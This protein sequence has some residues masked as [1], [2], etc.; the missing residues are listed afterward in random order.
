MMNRTGFTQTYTAAVRHL[1][2]SPAWITILG[3]AVLILFGTV[4]LILPL[5]TNGTPLAAVDALFT[6]TSA[7]CVTGLTVVD[8]GSR[9]SPFGQAV[10]LG[11]I[12]VGGLG[13]MTLGTLFLLMAGRRLS[14]AE[15]A[16]VQDSF[17]HSADRRPGDILRQVI[18]YTLA[19][20]AIGAG[21]L[22]PGF[23]AGMDAGKAA[24]N[25]IFHAVS[26]FCNAGFSL[27]PDSLS[28]YHGHWGINLVIAALVVA[29]G[30]G[31]LVIAEIA[32]WLPAR[33]RRWG[34]LSLHSKVV[35]T[36]TGGLLAAGFLAVLCMEWSNTLAPLTVPQRLLAAGFQSV[37]TR[38]A[39]FNSLPVHL[40]ANETL[41]VFILLMFI[42]ASP[43][44]CGGGI[45]TTTFL[46]LVLTGIARLRGADKPGIFYRQIAG[47]SVMKAFSVVMVSVG[48]VL[49][50]TLGL[51][52]TELGEVSH[53][54]SRGKF[55]EI[56][57]EVV[58]AFGTVGLSTG[59]TGAMS[60]AGKLILTALM[61][62]G[63]LGPLMLAYAISRP[64]PPRYRY[65]EENIMIG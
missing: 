59:V 28:G 56:A 55:L 21:L 15:R 6:A 22:Y 40:M 13:I 3:F 52:M 62:T 11:L 34:Q 54:Q 43:G 48:V 65:A 64:S 39:G 2:R 58:S 51:L 26:A 29:G 8:T 10:I 12:Q 17:T 57:F 7:V 37:T 20:E 24:W 14:L 49:I 61:F 30:L 33:H 36:T 5:A 23:A 50:G 9:F 60:Q 16:V 38:T 27:F 35:L 47:S 45:K 42:G 18:L 53:L 19:I 44:S 4:L 41:F 63:R 25:S 32:G 1:Y 31:F 46:T